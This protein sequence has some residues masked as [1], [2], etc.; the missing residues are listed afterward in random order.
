MQTKKV[1]QQPDVNIYK[2]KKSMPAV[3]RPAHTSMNYCF[4]S[5]TYMQRKDLLARFNYSGNIN[6]DCC[7]N[8]V[9]S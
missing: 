3:L 5:T 9:L 8:E 2:N 1:I 6:N 4:F 7:I